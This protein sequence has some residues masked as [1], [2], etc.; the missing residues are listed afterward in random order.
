[1][2]E[3]FKMDYADRKIKLPEKMQEKE[4]FQIRPEQIDTNHHVNNEQYIAMAKNYLPEN[5]NIH[6]MRAEYR[7]A[8]VLGDK[9]FPFV[10]ADDK[11]YLVS[12]ADEEQK[13]Y[14]I[15]EFEQ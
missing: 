2:E 6:K 7:K 1:M 8:A 10:Y 14:A 3:P 9:V 15:V 13:P 4:S 5:F 12:L 11:M